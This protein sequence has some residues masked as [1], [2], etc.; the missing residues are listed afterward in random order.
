MIRNIPDKDAAEISFNLT[1]SSIFDPTNGFRKASASIDSNIFNGKPFIFSSYFK[2]KPKYLNWRDLI[3]LHDDPYLFTAVGDTIDK[4][5]IATRY[6]AISANVQN[7]FHVK[8]DHALTFDGVDIG[9][10]G[11]ILITLYASQAVINNDAAPRESLTFKGKPVAGTGTMPATQQGGVKIEQRVDGRLITTYT[12]DAAD[13]VL[14]IDGITDT[15]VSARM[16]LHDHVR[17]EANDKA[18]HPETADTSYIS[19]SLDPSLTNIAPAT[20]KPGLV[21]DAA[22]NPNKNVRKLG[23]SGQ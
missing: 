10:N 13:L 7:L 2:N 15:S 19:I 18:I 3:R 6:Q 14:S 9:G 21:R 5:E 1:N 22:G 16:R 17:R 4:I 23:Q 11:K 12:C 8:G 20:D